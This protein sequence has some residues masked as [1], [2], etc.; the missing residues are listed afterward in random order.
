MNA[1]HSTRKRKALFLLPIPILLI[2]G[3]LTLHFYRLHQAD[4]SPPPEPA[5]WAIQTGPVE[6][7]S[8]GGAIETTARV[9]APQEVVLSP[10]IH[11]AVL[12]VG[13]R[14][15]VSV[16]QGDL[17]VLI[18]ARTIASNVSALEEQEAA[19]R[20]DAEYAEA[21]RKRVEAVLSEGGVSQAQADQARTAALAARARYQSLADQIAALKVQLGYA[22]I[23]APLDAVVAERMV[24]EGDVVG[25]GM[26]VY[27][28]EAG[29]GA[30]VRCELPAEQLATVH[31]GDTLELRL[32]NASVTLAITRIAPAVTASGLGALEADSP[33]VPFGLPSGS[34]VAATIRRAGSG[35]SLTVPVTAIVGQGDNAHVMVFHAPGDASEPGRLQR[36]PV[37][38]LSEDASRAAVSGE[39]RAGQQVVV[40][41]TAVLS[42]LKDG[43]PAVTGA[44]TRP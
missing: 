17:L 20:D 7:S 19:A 21:Q 4:R 27:R 6:R 3:A 41:Q 1:K 42:Q 9:T 37:H 43:D 30:I 44:G 33:E 11:G 35:E 14:S 32:G 13:P 8:V 16:A 23:R 15:G 28:L 25:P 39:V 2:T 31:I 12:T 5:P 24:E 29:R 34:A 26:P 22:E 10:Q 36:V 18:D 38:V 40:G